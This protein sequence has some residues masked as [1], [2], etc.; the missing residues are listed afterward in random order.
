MTKLSPCLACVL[1]FS[2]TL[3]MAQ[4]RTIS[5]HSPAGNSGANC[6]PVTAKTNRAKGPQTTTAHCS[7]APSNAS[8]GIPAQ[9]SMAGKLLNQKLGKAIPRPGTPDFMPDSS[10]IPGNL[11]P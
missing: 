1:V 6:G 3:A 11:L 8:F 4:K 9:A 5:P 2:C 7:S 10:T